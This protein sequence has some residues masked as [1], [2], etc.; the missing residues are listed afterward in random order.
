MATLVGVAGAPSLAEAASELNLFPDPR[1][2]LLNLA[3][4]LALVWP[5]K[6]FLL[7]PLLGVLEARAERTA[8]ALEQAEGLLREAA[9]TRKGFETRLAGAHAE[10]EARRTELLAEGEAQAREAVQAARDDAARSV[11]A[12]R[13]TVSTELTEARR[14]LRE[15]AATLASE[16]AGR[17]LGRA[18]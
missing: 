10:A 6:R 13:E 4:F 5:T 8:G 7:D 11:E 17:I 15:D 1:H 9:E 16:A 14:S 3:I 12:V 18:L 2:V